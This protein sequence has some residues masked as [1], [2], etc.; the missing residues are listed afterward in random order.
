MKNTQF[1]VHPMLV[2]YFREL[3]KWLAFLTLVGLL[4]T[5]TVDAIGILLANMPTWSAPY[6]IGS[7]LVRQAF[8][9]VVFCGLYVAGMLALRRGFVRI[10]TDLTIKLAS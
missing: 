7:F 8:R 6:E 10:S 1:T 9:V 5:S 2:A 3:N 4:L